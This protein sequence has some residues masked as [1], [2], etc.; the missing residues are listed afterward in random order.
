MEL[1]NATAKLD[2]IESLKKQLDKADIKKLFVV[3]FKISVL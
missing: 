2:Q 3:T 1:I